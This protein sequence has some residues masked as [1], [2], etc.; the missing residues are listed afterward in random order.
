MRYLLLGD[1]VQIKE[2]NETI[3]QVAPT[4]ISVLIT[5]ESGTG[6]EVAAN[7]IYK[8]SSRKDKPLITVNCGAIPE[9][10]IESELFGHE[11]GAF[12][13]AIDSREGYFEMADKGTIFL[14][15]IGEMPLLTQ[16]KLLRVLESGEFMRV[17]GNKKIKVDVRVIAATNKDLSKEVLNKNFREDL[18]FRLKSINLHIPPLRERKAD[19]VVLF[20]HFVNSFC[21]ENSVVFHGIDENAMDYLINYHWPGNARE[22][23]NFI[24]S[25]IVLNPDVK[26]TLDIVRR[27]LQPARDESS[28]LPA[29]TVSKNPDFN[30]LRGNEL[31]IRAL[32]EIK[33]DIID[34]RNHIYRL[35]SSNGKQQDKYDF[36][37]PREKM[38]EMDFDEIEREVLVYLLKE[39]HWNVSK[40]SDILKQSPRNIYRKI[41]KYH[42]REE[43]HN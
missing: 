32:A 13:G 33:S 39:N 14:D 38:T 43:D 18:Y 2:L 7:A 9:G 29:L 25:V 42:I 4:N 23:K 20:D 10:I 26:L 31:L 41:S 6:K 16:V 28:T 24:E 34:L 3:K 1:S 22:L 5:G 19:I 15:E 12:T 21:R 27:H 17:G 8:Q 30:E 35:E 40:V 11:K 36:V 37:I